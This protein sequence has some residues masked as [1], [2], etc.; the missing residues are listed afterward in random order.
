M[1]CGVSLFPT[2]Y[3]IAPAELARA[4]EERG[5]ESVWFPEHS[6][7]PLSRRSAWPGGGELPKMYTG[8]YFSDFSDFAGLA[9]PSCGPMTPDGAGFDPTLT[10]ARRSADTSARSRLGIHSA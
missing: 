4:A 3:S 2:D 7:I 6:H 1:H 8:I 10:G 9:S 5:F